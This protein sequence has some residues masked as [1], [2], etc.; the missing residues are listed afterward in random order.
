MQRWAHTL[1]H[2]RSGTQPG[3]APLSLGGRWDG[4]RPL[5]Q[6][7]RETSGRTGNRRDSFQVGTAPGPET[8][9]LSSGARDGRKQMYP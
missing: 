2:S 7:G 1:P 9:V 6:A 5:G 3:A 8:G 4:N